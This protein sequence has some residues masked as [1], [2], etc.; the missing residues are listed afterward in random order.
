M[1]TFNGTNGNDILPRA[2]GDN[3]GNDSFFPRLGQDIV[4]GGEG[5]DT[6]TI[7]YSGVADAANLSVGGIRFDE[8]FTGRATAGDNSVA[9]DFIENLV[10]KTGS[11]NDVFAVTDSEAFF[12]EATV[13]FNAGAGN[14]T[15]RLNVQELINDA[16]LL[17]SGSTVTSTL[18]KF[19]GFENYTVRTGY[20][21]DRVTTAGGIDNIDTGAGDDVI[22][23]GSGDDV[24][25]GR[26]GTNTVNAGAGNDSIRL[27]SGRATDSIDG[28]SGD[29]TLFIDSTGTPGFYALALAGGV[30]TDTLG[31]RAVNVERVVFDTSSDDYS[32]ALDNFQGSLNFRDSS[33][34]DDDMLTLNYSARTTNGSAVISELSAAG[35]S[36]AQGLVSY[37]GT[38]AGSVHSSEWTEIESVQ[39]LM[40]SGNDA[41]DVI[42]Q[43][44]GS[45]RA[46]VVDGG[47]GRDT[48]T[49][50][51][52]T[53]TSNL[54]FSAA[55]ENSNFGTFRNFENFK[56]WTGN[57]SDTIT[58]GGGADEIIDKG[59]STSGPGGGGN[60][61]FN[62]GGGND[63][64]EGGR[65]NDQ[66][67][68]GDGTDLA[69]YSG[70]RSNYTIVKLS[71]TSAR[72]TDKRTGVT[73]GVDVV[74]GIEQFQFSD[75][76]VSFAGLFGAV[77]VTIN[78]TAGNNSITPAGVV[79]IVGTTQ[80]PIPGQPLPTS[81]GD[82]L[83]GL[84]GNDILD[85]GAGSDIMH[86]G[87]GDDVFVV[88]SAGDQVVETDTGG[89]DTVRAGI[90]YTLGDT[91]EHLV[92]T[93]AAING[94]GN[95][96]NNSLTGNDLNNVLDGETGNDTLDGGLGG[97]TLVGG[98][99]DDTFHINSSDDT[100]I[101]IA[102]GG[103]DKV[104][105]SVSRSL[106]TGFEELTLIGNAITGKG[107]GTANK[108]TGNGL[109][110]LLFGQGGNDTVDGAAGNDTVQ[111]GTGLDILT[112]GAGADKFV[113]A[114][115]SA[116]SADT[117]TDFVRGADKLQ[118]TAVNY[119]LVAGA[120]LA[121][122]F[123]QGTNATT[124]SA[125]FLFNRAQS[126]LYWDADGLAGGAVKIATL[127]G[128]TT[129]GVADFVLM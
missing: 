31:S 118:F 129:L 110:N 77:G 41:V 63:I 14:D 104:F 40:G 49:L 66:L 78:G 74:N 61:I 86:G 6:L 50:Q 127:T 48:L 25:F 38:T 51:L 35:G 113:F 108:V 36:S 105:S 80:T 56:I 4:D 43:V 69:R 115:A 88:E 39:V 12:M 13:D 18:G 128:I 42:D 26:E 91:V 101:E 76:I 120:L 16:T 8:V 11:G 79:T 106:G 10:M 92:L 125:Q 34:T 65:G 57:G 112:G 7:D 33:K 37:P 72:I 99:G 123:Q 45:G 83:F 9:F 94:S 93:G 96:L 27:L 29:D 55:I 58:T 119:G 73:D 126:T 62:A 82:T 109:N 54:A 68:G 24:V 81:Q 98:L 30:V 85:G 70:A 95:A 53:H 19:A 107:N 52:Q 28:G 102:D 111:G 64:L 89:T 5:F 71:D 100:V 23:S 1:T 87:I 124:G 21:N 121:A 116:A 15:L 22:N 103:Y 122:D 60:D 44:N 2:G 67:A 97:D 3:S 46:L 75:G 114:A 20:G 17:V 117:I 32:V 47:G 90:D 84:A 59:T